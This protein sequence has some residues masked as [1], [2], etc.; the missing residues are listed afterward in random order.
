MKLERKY[1]RVRFSEA[2]IRQ[3]V[4]KFDETLG[5]SQDIHV[6]NMFLD[7]EHGDDKW[8]FGKEEEFFAAYADADSALYHRVLSEDADSTAPR[9]K[10]DLSFSGEGTRVGVSSGGDHLAASQRTAV[11]AVMRVLDEFAAD[12]RLAD[13]EA[14]SDA[15]PVVFIGH[16]RSPQWRDL[17]DHLADKHGYRV[18]AYE[19]GA[20]AGHA[21]RDILQS[22]LERSS[23]AVLVLTKEDETADGGMRARQNVV[24]E[25]GL[26]QGKLGFPR[27]LMILEEGTD[28]FSNIRGLEQI[29]FKDI[30]ETFGEVVATLRREFG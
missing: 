8:S 15:D 20:R 29:R 16:G 11:L 22:M 4:A 23:F 1:P 19:S 27:A 30:K 25:T 7:V 13:G 2:A 6:W 24:H 10:F 26:F 18:E 21:V 14:S 28:D 17:K 9:A 5:G 12:C 3:A